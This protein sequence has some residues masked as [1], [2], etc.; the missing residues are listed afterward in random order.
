M[1]GKLGAESSL[2][3]LSVEAELIPS[4]CKLVGSFMEKEL[5]AESP[6]LEKF[7]WKELANINDGLLHMSCST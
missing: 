4:D 2:I 1:E 5:G 6:M 3:G 7:Q